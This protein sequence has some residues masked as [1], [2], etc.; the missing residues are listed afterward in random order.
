VRF[1]AST[2]FVLVIT[3]GLVVLLAWAE[4]HSRRHHKPPESAETPKETA[5]P[6]P[7][8]SAKRRRKRS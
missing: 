7:A 2:I 4:I 6:E 5:P 8:Q 1:D 3:V